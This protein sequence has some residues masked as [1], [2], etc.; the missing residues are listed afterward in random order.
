MV[1][2]LQEFI[3]MLDRTGVYEVLLPFL[4]FFAILYGIVSMTKVLGERKGINV[5]FS[6]A[7]SLLI[8]VLHVT[9]S[10]GGLIDP[11]EIIQGAIPQLGLVIIGVISILI[12][13]SAFGLEIKA[14]AQGSYGIVILVMIN[15]IVYWKYP[16]LFGFIITLSVL[17]IILDQLTPKVKGKIT[18]PFALML[19]VAYLFIR[20][21]LPSDVPF[22]LQFTKDPSFQT[23]AVGAFIMFVMIRIILGKETEK[24]E[25]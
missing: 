2:Q 25:S 16:V 4:L 14:F 22:G 3:R 19:I 20:Q 5:A 11:V 15:A 21:T 9:H 18:L 7:I 10:Y 12:V 6:A 8:V 1:Q 17:V 23:L 24:K 13:G